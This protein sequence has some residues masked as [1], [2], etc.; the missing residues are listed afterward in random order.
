MDETR[1]QLNIDQI[2]K[3]GFAEITTPGIGIGNQTLSITG[4]TVFKLTPPA[5]ARNALLILEEAGAAGDAIVC[6]FW[7]DGTAPTTTIGLR[8][9]DFGQIIITGAQNLAN[10]QIIAVAS[11]LH[12]LYVE[13]YQ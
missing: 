7:V 5:G 9:P 10:F 2:V 8:I 6:R 1:N 12:K 3:Q 11:G 4:A 13:Y